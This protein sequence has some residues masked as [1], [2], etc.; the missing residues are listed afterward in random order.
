MK[1]RIVTSIIKLSVCFISTLFLIG[2]YLGIAKRTSVDPA[3]LLISSLLTF[4]IIFIILEFIFG[5]TEAESERD[6]FLQML[7]EDGDEK[8]TAAV[9][10]IRN[11]EKLAWDDILY[12][13]ENGKRKDSDRLLR[14]IMLGDKTLPSLKDLVA[15]SSLKEMVSWKG[16]KFSDFPTAL[17][18]IESFAVQANDDAALKKL[19]ALIAELMDL[20]DQHKEY[21]GSIALRKIIKDKCPTLTSLILASTEV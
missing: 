12:L 13:E 6:I 16:S 20:A 21:K 3:W 19:V 1:N 5:K 14:S 11:T 8:M 9:E 4:S 7:Y 10:R 17:D 2:L 18:L 15:I